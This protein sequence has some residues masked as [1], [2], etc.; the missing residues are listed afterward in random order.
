M[1]SSMHW[2]HLPP[3]SMQRRQAAEDGA[4]WLPGDQLLVSVQRG[5]LTDAYGAPAASWSVCG[6]LLPTSQR[7]FSLYRWSP[8]LPPPAL[9]HP[10]HLSS[11]STSGISLLPRPPL[12]SRFSF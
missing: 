7:A 2:E 8:T 5:T 12:F 10:P 4:Q 1:D 6:A 9:L 11:R 3:I